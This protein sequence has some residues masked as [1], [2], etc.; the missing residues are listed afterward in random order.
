MTFVKGRL[1]RAIKAHGLTKPEEVWKVVATY[2]D[3]IAAKVAYLQGR[4]F[5]TPYCYGPPDSEM[6]PL[7]ERQV[8]LHRAGFVSTCGQPDR[9]VYGGYTDDEWDN[10]Q[11][12][13][14][15][16]KWFY[17]Y[18]KRSFIR[19]FMLKEHLPG[20]LKFMDAQDEAD[21]KFSVVAL[22]DRPDGSPR[23]LHTTFPDD[24]DY[25]ALTRERAHAD[26][27]RLSSKPWSMDTAIPKFAADELEELDRD[28]PKA[29]AMMRRRCVFVTV[30][31]A[32]EF[33]MPAAA[34]VE[35][36]L[37]EFYQQQQ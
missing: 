11:T 33:G 7:I 31:S 15:C 25:Y 35:D 3:M 29:A 1:E 21:F 13:E 8:R 23:F 14:R 30:V 6:Q 2:D 10:P 16:G 4:V 5:S 28:Y 34:S 19:G 18:E 27:A 32:R 37:L 22:R 17:D 9:F 12:G 24:Q 26:R 36:L 20:F